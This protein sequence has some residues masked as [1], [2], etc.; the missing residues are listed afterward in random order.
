[1]STIKATF[2][3]HPSATEP[4]IELSADGSIVLPLS[5]IG[6]LA[7]VDEGSGAADGDVLTYDGTGDVWVP[8]GI[9]LPAGVGSNV[10]QTVK[11]NTQVISTTVNTAIM[12]AVITPSSATSKVLVISNLQFGWTASNANFARFTLVRSPSVIYLGDTDGS[13]NRSSS[14]ANDATATRITP[15]TLVFLDSPNTTSA[16][17]YRIEGQ[18]VGGDGGSIFINRAATDTNSATVPRVASSLTVIEVKA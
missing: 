13:R 5:G 7:D 16:T 1:M 4:S 9:V 15:V 3:Q 14:A 11:S 2:F 18:G 12:S 6:D 10:V 17:T 8:Q